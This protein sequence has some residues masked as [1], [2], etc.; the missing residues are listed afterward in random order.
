MKGKY[1]IHGKYLFFSYSVMWDNLCFLEVDLLQNVL[2]LHGTES[3]ASGMVK[4]HAP[5]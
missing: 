4:W 3:V 2:L 1:L 5:S